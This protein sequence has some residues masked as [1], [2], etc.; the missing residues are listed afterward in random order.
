LSKVDW[1]DIGGR[2]GDDDPELSL[3]DCLEM[4]AEAG[5]EMN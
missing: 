4:G 2:S 3:L 1:L 5:D